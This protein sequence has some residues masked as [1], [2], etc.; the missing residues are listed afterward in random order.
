[1]GLHLCY[2]CWQCFDPRRCTK[3][4][5]LFPVSGNVYIIEY[6]NITVDNIFT[7]PG[8]FTESKNI[9]YL[10]RYLSFSARDWKFGIVN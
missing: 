6:D 3:E 10:S 7:H 1:M 2:F 4:N 8:L 9:E 5:L